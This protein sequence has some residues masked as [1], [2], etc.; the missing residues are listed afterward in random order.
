MNNRIIGIF[1]LAF[2]AFASLTF[3]QCNDENTSTEKDSYFPLREGS[4]WQMARKMFSASWEGNYDTLI[5]RVDGDTIINGLSYKRITADGTLMQLVR[6]ENSKYYLREV[7]DKH[8]FSE[9]ILFLDEN[10]QVNSAWVHS[11]YR[12]YKVVAVN[13]V[14]TVNDVQYNNVIEMEINRLDGQGHADVTAKVYYAKGTGEIF[15]AFPYP[16]SGFYA[17]IEKKLLKYSP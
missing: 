9:E 4:S 1:R 11:S 2:I 15:G 13:S 7:W 16:L 10:A 3:Y 17:D 6:K 12:Q 14:Q 8:S 5:L